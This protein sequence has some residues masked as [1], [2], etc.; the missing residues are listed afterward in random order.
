MPKIRNLAAYKF[1]TLTDLRCRR[2]RLLALCQGWELKGT[3]LLSHEGINLF[4]AGL[5]ET[6]DALLAEL[7]TWPGLADLPL[8]FSETDHQPFRRMLVRLKKKSSP[9]GW[10]ASIP[11]CA[12]RP[13]CPRRR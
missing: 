12:P 7:R 8:K 2:A 1:V 5:P 4:V 13:N 10:M 3:I 11:P 6:I 9:L